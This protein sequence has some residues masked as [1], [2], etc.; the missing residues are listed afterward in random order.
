MAQSWVRYAIL[1][2]RLARSAQR[3]RMRLGQATSNKAARRA[4]TGKIIKNPPFPR[5][6]LARDDSPFYP[7]PTPYHRRTIPVP[8]PLHPRIWERN[9][10][11]QRRR[12][13]DG[14]ELVRRR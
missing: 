9:P 12:Y 13:G 4:A 8:A 10:N 2:R 6:F 14:I 11:M 7:L 5:A 1:T 3:E